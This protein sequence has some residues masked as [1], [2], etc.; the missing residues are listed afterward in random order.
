MIQGCLIF[1]Q[2]AI[3]FRVVELEI[4]IPCARRFGLM[5]EKSQGQLRGIFLAPAMFAVS[6]L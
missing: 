1:V 3:E 6:N 5:G 2:F 4:P